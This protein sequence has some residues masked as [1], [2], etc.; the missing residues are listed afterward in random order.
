MDKNQKIMWTV[1]G[2]VVVAILGYWLYQT[3][4]NTDDNTPTFV[5]NFSECAAAGYPVEESNPRQCRTPDGTV[6]VE[7]TGEQGPVVRDGCYVG[8]CSNTICSDEPGAVSTCE[9][10]PE[11]ACFSTATCERQA[12]GKCGWTE[13]E[14]FTACLSADLDLL[15]K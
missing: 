1:V 7:D 10:R 8:G 3:N 14:E 9:Y 2:V 11:Y 15:T 6:Y 13:T 12:S 4:K 5:T